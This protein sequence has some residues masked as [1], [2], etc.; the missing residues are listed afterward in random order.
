MAENEKNVK[1]FIIKAATNVFARYGFS[2][3]TMK[4]IAAAAKK[5]K[6]S[7]YHYF[8]GKEQVFMAIMDKEFSFLQD[9]ITQAISSEDA[10]EKKLRAFFSTRMHTIQKLTNFY[11]TVKDEYLEHYSFIEN[12]RKNY[13]K[14]EMNI[15]KNILEM[16]IKEDVFAIK[17]LETVAFTIFIILKGIEQSWISESEHERNEKNLDNM[18]NIILY[19]IN[20]R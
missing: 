6:S 16:G 1:E 7:L 18:M 15:I 12:F 8:S 3:T 19:G 13:D 5:A 14:V 4:D 9:E 17:D 10:P 2:K 20:K 11:S